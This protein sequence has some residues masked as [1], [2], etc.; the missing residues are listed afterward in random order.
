MEIMTQ[1]NFKDLNNLL[2]VLV[3]F[4]W[5]ALGV[6]AVRFAIGFISVMLE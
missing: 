2:R 6:W 3:V 5:I 1:I 4:G